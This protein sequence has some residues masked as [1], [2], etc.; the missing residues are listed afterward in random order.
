MINPKCF[1][2]EW[3]EKKSVELKYKDKNG[4]PVKVRG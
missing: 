4:S 2:T 3:I 1:T